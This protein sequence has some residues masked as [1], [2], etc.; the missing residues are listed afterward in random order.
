LEAELLA[1]EGELEELE[2]RAE[3]EDE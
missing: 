1:A 3:E 2:S